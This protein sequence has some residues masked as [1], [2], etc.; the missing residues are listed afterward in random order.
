MP[1][2]MTVMGRI[3]SVP[4]VVVNEAIQCQWSGARLGR[5]ALEVEYAITFD[6][7][8]C[9]CHD[10]IP[11]LH[12]FCLRHMLRAFHSMMGK[13]KCANCGHEYRGIQRL[14]SIQKI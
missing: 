1:D 12:R 2:H 8:P 9:G 14:Q 4:S 3:T 11:N 5:C 6:Y 13:V 7:P 10:N